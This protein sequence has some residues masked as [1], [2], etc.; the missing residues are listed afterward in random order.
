M[1]RKGFIF[2]MLMMLLSIWTISLGNS[3]SPTTYEFIII[4]P[5]TGNA[6]IPADKII[7]LAN[8]IKQLEE[9]NKNLKQQIEVYEKIVANYEEQ[10]KE[11]NAELEKTKTELANAK[12]ENFWDKVKG[13]SWQ[14]LTII[15]VGTMVYIF[16]KGG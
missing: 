1:H 15:S 2:I 5:E 14:V 7:P 8:Y 11:L 9:V 13:I 12:K 6:I 16:I 4:D 10:I 3:A